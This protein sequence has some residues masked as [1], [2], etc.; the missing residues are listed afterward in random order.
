M[1]TREN[2]E[3]RCLTCGATAPPTPGEYMTLIRHVCTGKRVVR[4]IDT[5]TGEEVASNTR[6]AL[7]RGL[8]QTAKDS[9]EAKEEPRDELPLETTEEPEPEL[10]LEPEPETGE[11]QFEVTEEPP[12]DTEDTELEQELETET[13]SEGEA[14]EPLAPQISS[15]GVFRYTIEL[16]ADAFALFNIAK[17][18]GLETDRGKTFDVWVWDC[19]RARFR[20]DYKRQLVLAGIEEG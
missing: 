1:K 8:I 10:E 3:W 9:K 13:T 20:T 5:A 4:L 18:A 15:E 12:E 6:Q 14:K 19:I 17:G 16:P 2:L 7:S 11:S